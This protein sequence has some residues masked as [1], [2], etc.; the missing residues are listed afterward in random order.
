MTNCRDW[1]DNHFQIKEKKLIFKQKMDRVA[2]TYHFPNHDDFRSQLPADKKY[3]EETKEAKEKIDNHDHSS[4]RI[5]V[6]D[7]VVD[8]RDAKRKCDRR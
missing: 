2:K 8:V 1:K 7:V 3:L 6:L 5:Q 4:N